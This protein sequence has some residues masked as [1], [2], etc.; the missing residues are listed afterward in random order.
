MITKHAYIEKDGIIINKI[1]ICDDTDIK[2]IGA[3]CSN[4]EYEIGYIFDS[5]SKIYVNP[6]PPIQRRELTPEQAASIV[7]TDIEKEID[8]ILR[9]LL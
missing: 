5:S 1:V 2:S 8:D 3:F 7:K 4:T 9:T 6:N